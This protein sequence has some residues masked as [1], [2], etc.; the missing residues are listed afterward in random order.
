MKELPLNS[1]VILRVLGVSGLPGPQGWPGRPGS[2]DISQC[3]DLVR[4]AETQ[5]HFTVKDEDVERNLRRAER[6]KK[7]KE[8]RDRRRKKRKKEKL[9][10]NFEPS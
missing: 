5:T 2:C 3:S 1:C 7:K 8:K 6:K 4:N 10:N 9:R